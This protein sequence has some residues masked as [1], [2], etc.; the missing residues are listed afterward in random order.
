MLFTRILEAWDWLE[1]NGFVQLDLYGAD[2][3]HSD[4]RTAT[5]HRVADDKGLSPC[6]L[7]IHELRGATA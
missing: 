6:E 4:G 2:F 3:A 5:I 7:V 1:E